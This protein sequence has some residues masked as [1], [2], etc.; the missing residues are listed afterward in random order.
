[1]SKFAITG[2][3]GFILIG[4]SVLIAYFTFPSLDYLL[5]VG[6][7]LI[8]IGLITIVQLKIANKL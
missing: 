6:S 2:I 3:I 8:I 4:I 7:I 1:M 5:P